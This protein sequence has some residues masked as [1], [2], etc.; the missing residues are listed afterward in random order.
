MKFFYLFLA[1]LV[2]TNVNAQKVKFKDGQVLVDKVHK[3]DFVKIDAKETK[4]ELDHYILSDL[5]GNVILSMTDTTFYFDQLP[6]ELS[7]R[8]AYHA[9]AVN[10]P[11]AGLAGV[12]PYNPVMGYPK[13]RINDLDKV[14]FFK[15]SQLDQKKFDDF[16]EKQNAD[17]LK[18]MDAEREQT[19]TSRL[20]NYNLTREKLGDLMEREPGT[21]SVTIN[22]NQKNGYVIRDGNTV[23]GTYLVISPDS[24]KP[25][26]LVYNNVGE[27]IASGT[28]FKE[29][30]TVN[31]LEQYKYGL[32][33]YAYGKNDLDENFKWF[34]ER[35][36]STGTQNSISD[37]LE[38][39]ATFLINEGFL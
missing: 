33:L 25:G 16:L 20:E 32:K 17:Y 39:M 6:N 38:E 3:Y 23:V 29:P 36:K 22:I 31:G 28:I 2:F 26:L 1:L 34:Y 27:E 30:E 18:T 35:V 21:I 4:S 13:Q 15:D 10:A 11:S 9:Y 7:P 14:G 37:K 24:Y 8:G 19:N 5:E 12:M